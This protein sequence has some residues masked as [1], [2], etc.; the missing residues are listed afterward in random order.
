MI[1]EL[2][3]CTY[4]VMDTSDPEIRFDSNGRCNHCTDAEGKLQN[5]WFRG[6]EG[7]QR[8]EQISID[9]QDFGKG[10]EFDC[11]IGISGGVDSCYLVYVAVEIMKLRPL[12]VHVDAGWNTEA[13][14]ANIEKIVRKYNLELHTYVVNWH[15][16]QD[17]QLAY[18]KSSLANQDVPQDHAFFAK[19]YEFAVKNKIKYVLTGS[20]LSSESILPRSWGYDANDSIQLKAIHNM[21]GKNKLK[22]YPLMSFF[23]NKI[24]W[25]YIKKMKVIKPLNFIDY[26]KNKAID[27]LQDKF[28]WKY[29]ESKWTKFFQA[30]YLV[31]KFGFDKR[32]AHLSSLIVSKQISREEALV[33]IS[34]P[35]Y[36]TE[37]LEEDKQYIAQKLGLSCVEFESLLHLENRIY[38]DYPNQEYRLETF[39]KLKKIING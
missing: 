24:Y 4:C 5:G 12:V 19:L 21:F 31:E 38:K 34:K 1:M 3:V 2:R 37:D 20:N 28:G 18:L 22:T 16:M 10:K 33:E 15:E 8:L 32:K 27:F 36:R 11:I 30:Y 23:K 35:L 25:P 17:L 26:D 6:E 7:K 29:H 13:A 14:V 39:R 9:I